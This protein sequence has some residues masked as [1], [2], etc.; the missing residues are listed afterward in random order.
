MGQFWVRVMANESHEFNALSSAADIRHAIHV[1]VHGYCFSRS[2][3][4]PYLAEQVVPL[5]VMRDAPRRSGSYRSEEWVGYDLAADEIDRL[6]RKHARGA[7]RISA[8]CGVGDSQDPLRAGF[9]ALG[10]RLGGTESLMIHRLAQIPLF[11]AGVTIERVQTAGQAATFA[12]TTRTR[13]LSPEYFLATS[14]LRQYMAIAGDEGI[15]WVRSIAVENAAWCADMFVK[16]AFRRRGIARAMLSRM[17]SDDRAGGAQAS[18]LLAGH[19]GAMLYPVVGY[20][21]IGTLLV[22]T[23][24]KE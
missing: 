19:T 11:E 9:K 4:H 1:F 16:P 8:I 22:F 3:T 24:K 15:G 2:F 6:V 12:Q 17:L 20:E 21:Q 14:P 10:Y 18:V 23:P 5:W 7:F 13:P